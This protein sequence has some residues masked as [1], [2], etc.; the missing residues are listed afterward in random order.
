MLAGTQRRKRSEAGNALIEFTIAYAFLIP[1]VLGLGAF[2]LGM[3]KYL[4]VASIARTAGGMF[5]R[6]ADFT[7]TGYQKILGKVSGDLGFADANYNILTTGKGVITLTVLMRIG[8]NQCAN[9]QSPYVCNNKNKVVVIKQVVLGNRSLAGQSVFGNP[10]TGQQSDGSFD[11]NIYLSTSSFV[12]TAF[13]TASSDTTATPGVTLD[14][15]A[16]ETAYAAEAFFVAPEWNLFP[17]IYNQPGYY[18]RIYF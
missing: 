10:T 6:G 9:I 15:R 17:R 12:V 5:V 14:L 16:G 4:Q 8:T 18:H 11:S 3:I 13:G 7:Q 2:G 1:L